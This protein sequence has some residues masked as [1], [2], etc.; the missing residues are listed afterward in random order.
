MADRSLTTEVHIAGQDPPPP[1]PDPEL[2]DPEFPDPEFPDPELPEP[3]PPSFRPTRE[4][5]AFR[6]FLRTSMEELLYDERVLLIS[7]KLTALTL[8]MAAAVT[9]I[10]EYFMLAWMQCLRLRKRVSREV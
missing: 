2:P 3:E 4:G 6:A 9:S 7:G 5:R 1:P 8:V 10:T